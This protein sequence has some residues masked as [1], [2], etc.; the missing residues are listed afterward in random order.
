MSLWA[1]FE[2]GNGG[3]RRPA[4]FPSA[5]KP[6]G[7]GFGLVRDL[8][9]EATAGSRPLDPR[10]RGDDDLTKPCAPAARTG[11]IVT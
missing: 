11:Q 1:L 8:I 4:G 6:A 3:L 10:F 9:G 5:L 2:K 7:A